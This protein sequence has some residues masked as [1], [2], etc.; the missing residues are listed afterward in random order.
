MQVETQNASA[1]ASTEPEER[2]RLR[3]PTA[4]RRWDVLLASLVINTAALALPM[5][6]LQIYDRILSTQALET[7]TLLIGG[8]VF[9]ALIEGVMRYA[10]S[11]ML[12]WDGARYEH[13]QGLEL[14]NHLLSAELTHFNTRPVGNYLDKF[15][16]LRLL[17]DFYTG[18]SVLLLVDLPFAILFVSL[19]WLFAG[20]LVA[21]P[22]VVLVAF[23]IVSFSVGGKLRAEIS[24]RTRSEDAKR[25]FLIETLQAGHTVKAMAMEA[26]ML[27]RY[28]RLQGSLSESVYHVTA[29]NN[30]VQGLGASLSQIVMV[31]FVG[32]GAYYVVGGNLT[33]GA[34]AA[35]T[36]LSGRIL[37]PAL[38]A[39]GL[40]AQIQSVH[41]AEERLREAYALPRES[42]LLPEVHEDLKGE[43]ELR[44]VT[45]LQPNAAT[46]LF[47]DV[48][49][50]IEAGESIGL[51]GEN[52]TGKSTLLSLLMG[53]AEPEQGQVLVDGL[54]IKHW[55]KT[56]L[57]ARIALLPQRGT[58]FEGSILDNMTLFRDGLAVEKALAY[59]EQLGL[60]DA[61]LRL[62]HGLDTKVG[63]AS[64]DG[65]PQGVRQMILMVRALVG[66]PQYGDPNVWLFDDANSC[67][68]LHCNINLMR[69]LA[70]VQGQKTLIIVSHKPRML[71][72]CDRTFS[73]SEGGFK[74]FDP[75]EIRKTPLFIQEDNDRRSA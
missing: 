55:N 72:M 9:F 2:S 74:T 28:E 54:D 38:K 73:I 29:L 45:Y 63:G 57:R 13:Q 22:L 26:Q 49:L 30:L 62:P 46:P 52:G 25:N 51:Y 6:I 61:V 16:Q 31:G 50:H 8:L 32:I 58:L 3:K 11:A 64:V 40:W 67:L 37:Q 27:R 65:I 1:N 47:D 20:A 23:T 41:V 35:G 24:N 56:R 70:R 15:E 17:R 4:W 42:T 59:A 75:K 36:M 66:N 12:A 53:Y 60:A 39:L 34:L 10:R 68:D 71:E 33:I 19:I 5:V 7:F 43:F 69:M 14:V 21:V 44:G 48:D 18:Q